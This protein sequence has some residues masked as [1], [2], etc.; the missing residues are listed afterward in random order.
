MSKI[1]YGKPKRGTHT[2]IIVQTLIFAA[3]LALGGCKTDP[4]IDTEY[5]VML[6][7][8]G[9]SGNYPTPTEEAPDLDEELKR[10]FAA[11]LAEGTNE[12]VKFTAQVNYS[13]ARQVLPEFKGTQRLHLV[14]GAK[15]W[16]YEWSAGGELKKLY[17]AESLRDF[18]SWSKQ[19][20]PAKNYILVLSDHGGGWKPTEDYP[21]AASLSS[22]SLLSS[23]VG[24]PV[25]GILFDPN[26]NN[27]SLSSFDLAKGIKES[28]TKFE[29][30]FFAACYMNMLE[31]L[32]EIAESVHYTY[33]ANHITTSTIFNMV[34]FVKQLKRGGDIVQR[35]D[36]FAGFS[37]DEWDAD[38]K[39]NKTNDNIDIAF[40][41]LTKL[42]GVFSAVKRAADF[43]AADSNKDVLAAIAKLPVK[44]TKTAN[45]VDGVYFY[46]SFSDGTPSQRVIES[47]M[48]V[49]VYQF[50]QYLQATRFAGVAE[51]AAIVDGVESACRIAVLKGRE[52]AGMPISPT[53]FGVNL[54]NYDRMYGEGTWAAA[55]EGW[56]VN[57]GYLDL[58][59]VKET[60]W[61]NVFAKL[62]AVPEL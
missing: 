1:V 6:Y 50:L 12:N 53:T 36:E 57:P 10:D 34:E 51:F 5:T 15:E 39:E 54:I 30:V 38:Q 59:F 45:N 49:D 56:T 35:M 61:Q 40:V 16:T 14:P 29:M 47:F 24:D 20:Y 13:K 3:L 19:T 62:I 28:G 58:K 26:F 8:V 33:G 31:N 44:K 4:T 46:D 21:K 52:S 55:K 43:L 32:G 42:E 9:D 41:D 7:G 2:H 18:I 22:L 11:L 17:L 27:E 23:S 48:F 25:Y 60:G 37:M